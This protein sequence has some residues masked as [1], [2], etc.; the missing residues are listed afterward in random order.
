MSLTNKK[1]RCCG[2]PVWDVLMGFIFLVVLGTCCQ[3]VKDADR[4]NKKYETRP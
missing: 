3:G 1:K 4:M 2:M